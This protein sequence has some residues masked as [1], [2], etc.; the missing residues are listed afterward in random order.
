MSDEGQGGPVGAPP[1]PVQNTSHLHHRSWGSDDWQRLLTTHFGGAEECFPPSDVSPLLRLTSDGTMLTELLQTLET[2]DAGAPLDPSAPLFSDETINAILGEQLRETAAKVANE[3]AQEQTQGAEQAAQRMQQMGLQPAPSSHSASHMMS[4]QEATAAMHAAHAVQNQSL[5]APAW[6]AP[7]SP[8]PSLPAAMTNR[9]QH[10][11]IPS[12]V[13]Q[14]HRQAPLSQQQTQPV[15]QQQ[16][17]TLLDGRVLQ[18]PDGSAVLANLPAGQQSLTV[19]L[20][21]SNSVLQYIPVL[22]SQV[23]SIQQQMQQGGSLP[24]ISGSPKQTTPGA[25]LPTPS[26]TPP[27]TTP[28]SAAAATAAVYISEL[29]ATQQMVAA[30]AQQQQRLV[31]QQQATV[32]QLSVPQTANAAMAEAVAAVAEFNLPMQGG[33]GGGGSSINTSQSY[34]QQQQ[35]AASAP[36][37][38]QHQQ[39]Q[40]QQQQQHLSAF[41]SASAFG[42]SL[43]LPLPMAPPSPRLRRYGSGSVQLN[44]AGSLPLVPALTPQL[45]PA[46]GEPFPPTLTS[47]VVASARTHQMSRAASLGGQVQALQPQ[48]HDTTMHQDS[49]AIP[50]MVPTLRPVADTHYHHR[51]QHQHHT[52]SPSRASTSPGDSAGAEEGLL[53]RKPSHKRERSLYSATPA[54]ADPATAPT[55]KCSKADMGG[56]GT[57]HIVMGTSPDSCLLGSVAIARSGDASPLQSAFGT[58]GSLPLPDPPVSTPPPGLSGP[59]TTGN[60]PIKFEETHMAGYDL[61][62]DVAELMQTA[63]APKPGKRRGRPP[64]RTQTI[65]AAVGE[66]REPTDAEILEHLLREDPARRQLPADEIKKLV[67]REKNRISAA[68]SRARVQQYTAA[69]ESRVRTLQAEQAELYG[70]LQAPPQALPHRVL[71][72]G[73]AAAAAAAMGASSPTNPRPPVRHLSL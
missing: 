42:S 62:A 58:P 29:S 13:P 38:T 23:V 59:L 24:T 22:S 48:Q 31:Q 4:L 9:Q 54:L 16:Y 34:Q 6:P 36:L 43:S 11:V 20:A 12:L 5:P 3:L 73:P 50:M 63:L 30:A 70:W 28:T 33:S 65:P 7:S 41:E 72:V 45:R 60:T 10:L 15:Q 37:A 46:S 68:I 35:P 49:R 56:V 39:P 8:V 57:Q 17:V 66:P 47:A 51:V 69:L 32:V 26:S 67:R 64:G 52:A 27:A 55:I 44:P 25:L 71:L 2:G 21:G 14:Q 19:T 1:L 61:N 40:Q 18:Q 53:P